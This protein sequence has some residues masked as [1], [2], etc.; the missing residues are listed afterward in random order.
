ML[1]S[2]RWRRI[3]PVESDTTMG[4]SGPL[5]CVLMVSERSIAYG[6][7]E[8]IKLFASVVFSSVGWL[9]AV[10]SS[11]ECWAESSIVKVF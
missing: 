6:G 2:E 8:D 4:S 10:G 1:F 11:L 5:A 3:R 7:R 9:E